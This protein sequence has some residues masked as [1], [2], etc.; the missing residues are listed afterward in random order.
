MTWKSGDN[1]DWPFFQMDIRIMSPEYTSNGY[2][3][4]VPGITGIPTAEDDEK[5]NLKPRR[6]MKVSVTSFEEQKRCS[7]GILGFQ[8]HNYQKYCT[9][10]FS[11]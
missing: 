2:P 1:T 3:Y 6:S 4:Y 10:H 5:I 9:I 8:F 11:E 7:T